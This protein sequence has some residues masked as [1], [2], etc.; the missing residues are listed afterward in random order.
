[1]S[2]W[3][4]RVLQLLVLKQISVSSKTTVAQ[5]GQSLGISLGR[6]SHSM[7]DM[8]G[9]ARRMAEPGIIDFGEARAEAVA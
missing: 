8:A 7:M 4:R 6:R 9:P 3:R 5:A 1:M 2:G